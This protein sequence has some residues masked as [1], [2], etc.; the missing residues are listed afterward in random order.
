MDSR[1]LVRPALPPLS[2][3]WGWP[4]LSVGLCCLL[5]FLLLRDLL[6]FTV[7]LPMELLTCLFLGITSSSWAL[8]HPSSG[9]WKIPF[10]MLLHG[11]C[12]G[13]NYYKM[14]EGEGGRTSPDSA[15]WDLYSQVALGAP[16]FVASPA[17][18]RKPSLCRALDGGA[19]SCR[20]H[21]IIYTFPEAWQLGLG[22]TEEVQVLSEAGAS[23]VCHA[24]PVELL[25]ASC[26]YLAELM[27]RECGNNIF[28]CANTHAL[29][30]HWCVQI[31][32]SDR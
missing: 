31:S 16:C 8:H 13:R 10:N 4:L 22:L 21:E 12:K 11:S 18:T 2:L 15:R 20:S 30:M 9:K 3:V 29:P 27:H 6:A 5:G 1:P 23:Y 24:V 19:C 7:H 25:G 17:P 28:Q 14:P 26:P 32:H